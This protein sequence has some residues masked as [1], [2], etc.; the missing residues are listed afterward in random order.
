MNKRLTNDN[1]Y[2]IAQQPATVVVVAAAK[3]P[4]HLMPAT[5]VLACK[6]IAVRKLGR[7]IPPK[8]LEA[9]EHNQQIASCCRHPEEH[10]IEAFKSKPEET[11]PDIYILHCRC[12][13]AHRRFCVGGGDK[14]PFWESE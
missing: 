12:G 2:L 6:R 1:P 5:R 14:R 10:D 11:A 7:L 8:F 4:G 13:R 3:T 9:L